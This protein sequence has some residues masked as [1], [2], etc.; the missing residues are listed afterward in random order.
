MKLWQLIEYNKR[1]IFYKNHAENVV[2]RL[3]PDFL[4]FFK[5]ALCGSKCG[6]QLSINIFP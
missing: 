3:I 2:G 5:K 6:L 4:P 1:N